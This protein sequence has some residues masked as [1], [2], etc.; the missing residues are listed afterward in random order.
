MVIN[1][2]KQPQESFIFSS[3][4][5]SILEEDV[6]YH[7]ISNYRWIL[8]WCELLHNGIDYIKSDQGSRRHIW[9]T[10]FNNR[11]IVFHGI[12]F[13]SFRDDGVKTQLSTV[14]IH[15][16]H[17]YEIYSYYSY[18]QKVSKVRI[19]IDFEVRLFCIIMNR[20]SEGKIINAASSDLVVLD[21]GH[22]FIL[23]LI[24]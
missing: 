3:I 24:I 14:C 15:N 2:K 10:L 12:F 22:F 20:I 1:P 6:L 21:H 11:F 8:G 4:N 17:S 5:L 18:L 9:L 16:F 13:N 19:K 7:N 23:H